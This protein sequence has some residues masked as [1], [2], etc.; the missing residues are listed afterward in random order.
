MSDPLIDDI[1]DYQHLVTYNLD[2]PLSYL[3]LT[4]NRD[5]NQCVYITKN[6]VF[7]CFHRFHD[8]VHNGDTLFQGYLIDDQFIVTDLII[9]NNRIQKQAST[10]RLALCNDILD[11]LYTYD[12]ILCDRKITVLEH[13]EY[14]YLVSLWQQRPNNDSIDGLLFIP[15]DKSTTCIQIKNIS[16]TITDTVTKLEDQ[17]LVPTS[18]PKTKLACFTV[19]PTSTSDVYHIYLRRLDNSLAKY[20]TAGV[21]DKTTSTMLH[22]LFCGKKELLMVCEFNSKF[23]RWIPRMTSKQRNPDYVSAIL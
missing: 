22:G 6:A 4:T 10:E 21:P 17:A 23:G 3:F 16:D 20:D 11:H 19:R 15:A 7:E 13:V 1:R 18:T 14:E 8:D 5:K 2:Q 9:H 12:P